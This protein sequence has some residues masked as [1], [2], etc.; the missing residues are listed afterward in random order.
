[1]SQRV[2]IVSTT[3]TFGGGE[4]YVQRVSRVYRGLGYEVLVLTRCQLLAS[5]LEREGADIGVEILAG[6]WQVVRHLRKYR[7]SV[8][9]L[10]GHR[11]IIF[12]I[13]CKLLGLT[14][15][16]IRHTEIL[17]DNSLRS[18]IKLFLYAFFA[19]FSDYVVAVS[20]TVNEQLDQLKL[21]PQR[22]V[23][24]NWLDSLPEMRERYRE[25]RDEFV[26]LIVARLDPLK[27]HRILFDACENLERVRI[28]VLGEGDDSLRSEFAHRKDIVFQGFKRDVNNYYA[29]AD[30]FVLPTYT[31]GSPLGVLEAMAAGLPVILSDI[32]TIAEFIEPEKN[33]LLFKPG[34]VSEL[35]K[36]IV[37]LRDDM[38]LANRLGHEAR[39]FIQRERN[40]SIAELGFANVLS[41]IQSEQ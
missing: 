2:A 30:A 1:M 26:I 10:N 24:P 36:A 11:D 39:E 27:G 3:R 32:P 28:H 29:I 35:R 16:A 12:T 14:T 22:S 21:L 34:S 13:I 23:V 9:H 18:Y 25:P 5:E 41:Q 7:Y 38:K 4:R 8:V 37:R 17:R 33:G 20:S 6:H 40:R 31:E 15:L 19:P